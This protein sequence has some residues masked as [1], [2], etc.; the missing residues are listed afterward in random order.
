V[1]WPRMTPLGSP[2][3]LRCTTPLTLLERRE[4]ERLAPRLLH[5]LDELGVAR[6][7]AELPVGSGRVVL[8][9]ISPRTSL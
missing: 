1:P 4:L 3:P 8:S 5:Q 9:G 7:L 2:W 6:R